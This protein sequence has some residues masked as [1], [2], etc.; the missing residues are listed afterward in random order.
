MNEPHAFAE[1]PTRPKRLLTVQQL[2]DYLGVPVKTL[3]EWRAQRVGPRAVKVGRALR[4]PESR[5]VAWLS[6]ITPHTFRKTVATT[7]DQA[8][9]TDLA[10]ELL[11]HAS[12]EVTEAFY[13]QPT[14]RVNPVTAAILERLA[15]DDRDSVSRA[16]EMDGDLNGAL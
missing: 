6:G 11:G 10:A 2:S 13:I 8:A 15:P 3:Y 1:L 4:Y 9:T 16:G 7:I 14:K 5:V 12:K